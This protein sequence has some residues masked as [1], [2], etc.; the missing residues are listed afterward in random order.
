MRRYSAIRE[1]GEN[2]FYEWLCGLTDGEGSFYIK[3][4]GPRGF[5]F[6]FQLCLHQDD[7][8]MLEFIQK[9]LG[10]GKIFSYRSQVYF[11]VTKQGDVA[12]IIDIFDSYPLN[13]HK[14]LNFLDFKKAYGLYVSNK[15]RTLELISEINT[16]RRGMNTKRTNFYTAAEPR[17][18]RITPY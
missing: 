2:Q 3:S 8:E 12:R 10:M 18:F 16:L 11:D 17:K 5:S 4:V 9:K 15:E 6:R 7:L 13:T 14:H 1:T